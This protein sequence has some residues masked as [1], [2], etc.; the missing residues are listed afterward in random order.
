MSGG[1]YQ[2]VWDDCL[3]AVKIILNK[4]AFVEK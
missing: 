2:Q 4:S 1:S 3:D